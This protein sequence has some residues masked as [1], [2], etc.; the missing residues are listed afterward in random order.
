MKVNARNMEG[1]VKEAS[2]FAPAI[3]VFHCRWCLPESDFVRMLLPENSRD[4]SVV[5]KLNCTSRMEAEFAIKAFAEGYDGVLILGCEMGECHYRT[6]N[7]LAL[8]RFTL[9]RRI[10]E[11]SGIYPERLSFIFVSPYDEEAIRD[12]VK[13]FVDDVILCGPFKYKKKWIKPSRKT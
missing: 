12:K 8:K 13:S 2:D 6:G 10:L 5:V 11:L 9:F 1:R 3:A 4:R 7:E